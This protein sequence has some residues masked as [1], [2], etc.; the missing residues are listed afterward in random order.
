MLQSCRRQHLL[1][2]LA[3]PET[4]A[5]STGHGCMRL[6]NHADAAARSAMLP[7]LRM[8][9]A[10]YIV[11]AA[12]MPCECRAHCVDARRGLLHGRAQAHASCQNAFFCA[13]AQGNVRWLRF[14]KC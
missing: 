2:R 9:A 3:V 14:R 4:A 5:Y 1:L 12:C 8:D 13:R 7:P 6:P 11:A 10:V